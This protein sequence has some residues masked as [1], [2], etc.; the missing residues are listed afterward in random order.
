MLSL[1]CTDV[2]TIIDKYVRWPGNDWREK[3]KIRYNTRSFFIHADLLYCLHYTSKQV[4][5]L[6]LNGT[7]IRSHKLCDYMVSIVFYNNEVH[8]C[9]RNR[10]HTYNLDFEHLRTLIRNCDVV[11]FNSRNLYTVSSFSG[12]LCTY[13]MQ[14]NELCWSHAS[15]VDDLDDLDVLS[16]GDFVVAGP[17]V[18]LLKG[19]NRWKKIATCCNVHSKTIC[20]DCVDNIW[21]SCKKCGLSRIN[22]KGR[23]LSHM[24]SVPFHC[25]K[26]THTGDLAVCADWYH[27]KIRVYTTH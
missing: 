12:N 25:I 10:M 7:V 13:D 5:V 2:R 8:A 11:A 27:S 17:N 21:V 15:R 20:V 24:T 16:N 14:N 9:C 1:L 4:D 18:F 26:F 22:H 3:T 19:V 23:V 6:D